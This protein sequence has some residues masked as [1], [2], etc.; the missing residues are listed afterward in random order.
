MDLNAPSTSSP[1]RK[2]T[3]FEGRLP[4]PDEVLVHG[5]IPGVRYLLAAGHNI[6]RFC[7]PENPEDPEAT[8]WDLTHGASPLTIIG[9]KG[10]A[11][12]VVVLSKGAPI[13]GASRLNG[14]RQWYYDVDI[15][16][17]TGLDTSPTTKPEPK[18]AKEPA[19]G[20][21]SEPKQPA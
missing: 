11:T 19:R 21:S 20:Q 16:Q 15:S 6:G 2:A 8:G 18:P 7:A 13:R 4:E 3:R 17:V 1:I 12:G 10:E 5:G 9:P 14:E